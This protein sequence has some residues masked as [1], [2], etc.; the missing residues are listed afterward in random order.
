MGHIPGSL[1]GNGK[2]ALKLFG[3]HPLFGGA[4]QVYPQEPLCQGQMRI[5]KNG[6]H[7]DREL[8]PAIHAFIK[9]TNLFGF[10]QSLELHYP[11][12]PALDTGGAMGPAN[13]LKVLDTL[14][15]GVEALENFKDRRVLIHGLTPFPDV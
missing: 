1:I 7:G 15:F 9:I 12:T 6:S 3:R 8:I 10:P 5:V 13:A 11:G 4:D 14:F 2:L